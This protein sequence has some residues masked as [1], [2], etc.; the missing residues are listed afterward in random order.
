MAD[1]KKL[2]LQLNQP[3]SIELLYD[4]PTIG[5]S[6]YGEYYLYAVRNGDCLTE[7]SMFASPEVH[8]KLKDL[9][10]GCKAII[11]KL[12]EQRGNKILT[13]YDVAVQHT[14]SVVNVAETKPAQPSNG[15]VIAGDNFYELMLNSCKDAV[16][17]SSELGGMMDAKSLAVTL[18][19][20]RSR[21][22]ANGYGG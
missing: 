10:K 11:T 6:Q 1:R 7:Y 17:I 4:K 21:I 9:N 18:F 14:A 22:S 13:K 5:T 8:D 15:N 2:E 20:A 19:I 3:C 12:A 16:R